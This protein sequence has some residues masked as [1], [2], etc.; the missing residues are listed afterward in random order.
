MGYFVQIANDVGSPVFQ[1]ARNYPDVSFAS[2]ALFH[3]LVTASLEQGFVP[4]ILR[5]KDATIALAVHGPQGGRVSVAL[6]TSEL[7]AG[8]SRDLEAELHW[9]MSVVYRGALLIAGGELLRRQ[10]MEPLR[11]LLTQRL[12]PIVTSVMAEEPAPGMG[13]RVPRLGLSL[14]GTAVEWLARSRCAD[15]ALERC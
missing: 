14:R 8:Q 13:S 11:R 6:V 2:S 4:S 3:A 5:A 9:R 12:T 15:A 1:A 7:A 10:P